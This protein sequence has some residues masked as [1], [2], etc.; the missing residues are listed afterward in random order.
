MTHKST[1]VNRKQATLALTAV[2]GAVTHV[3]FER[4]GLVPAMR[5]NTP[6]AA[7]FHP[8]ARRRGERGR[9]RWKRHRSPQVSK[10]GQLARHK[11]SVT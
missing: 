8:K 7:A 5:R 11:V 2:G 10:T 9:D 3:E 1:L 6:W 4:S